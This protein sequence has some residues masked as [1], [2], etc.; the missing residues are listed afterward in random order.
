MRKRADNLQKKL[1]QLL[2]N[3]SN[4]K[5]LDAGCGSKFNLNF[6]YGQI[7]EIDIS[8]DQLKKYPNANKK[9]LG[10][11][12]YYHLSE[13]EYNLIICW[14]VLE[15]VPYP[16][17]ALQNFLRALKPD[18]FL[19]LVLP[20][21]CSVKGLVTKFTPF[22][23]HKWAHKKIYKHKTVVVNGQG[24]FRTYLRFSISLP[25]IQK[26]GYKN[27]LQ[28]KY[29]SKSHIVKKL[30]KKNKI[31]SYIYEIIIKITYVLSFGLLNE[32]E[33]IIVFQ[34]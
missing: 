1:D 28:I 17:K 27:K 7:T 2:E 15:H 10:D 4:I 12:Q 25:A 3:N 16:N 29:L 30:R 34:K 6:K 26:W 18:G 23:V 9:I 22:W 33:F 19:V 5:I 24:P 21:V 11:I 20:N 32:S 31:F 13:S 8:P 14:C